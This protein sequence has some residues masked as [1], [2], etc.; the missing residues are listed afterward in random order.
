MHPPKQIYWL[1][2]CCCFACCD[3]AD[4]KTTPQVKNVTVRINSTPP[5]AFVWLC[6]EP[7]YEQS[8]AVPFGRTPLLRLL[9]LSQAGISV[10]LT[11][12]GYQLW[13]GELSTNAAETNIAL[14][15]LTKAQKQ[16]LGW[17]VSP[18]C[19]RLTVVPLRLGIRKHTSKSDTLEVS[20]DAVSFTNRFLAA[21]TTAIAQRFGNRVGFASPDTLFAEE[22]YQQ[23]TRQMEGVAIPS[24]GFTPAPIRL[25]YSPDTNARLGVSDGAVLF[26]RAEACYMSGGEVFSRAIPMLLMAGIA[27]ASV[28]SGGRG[29]FMFYGAPPSGDNIFVQMFMIHSTTREL[30]WFGQLL[31]PRFFKHKQVTETV[32]TKA[33]EHIPSALLRE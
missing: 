3:A 24:I 29:V 4:T 18:P 19:R 14:N 21:F 20:P 8:R 31:E 11:K 30:M 2:A 25:D 27:G 9:Q 28:A 16:K 22:F 26:V 7:T 17:F 23:L 15:P 33:T 13:D 6:L 10:R 32:A 5:G 12:T 1:I